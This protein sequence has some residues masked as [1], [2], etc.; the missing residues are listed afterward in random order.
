MKHEKHCHKKEWGDKKQ[1]RNAQ[2]KQRDEPL[3]YKVWKHETH[4]AHKDKK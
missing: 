2:Q 4:Y 1:D 3:K